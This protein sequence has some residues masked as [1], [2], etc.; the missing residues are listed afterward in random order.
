MYLLVPLGIV[1]G[2]IAL[3]TNTGTFIVLFYQY[4]EILFFLNV[5]E[6][7]VT[8]STFLLNLVSRIITFHLYLLN[9]RYHIFTYAL[10]SQP[11]PSVSLC[12]LCLASP[13]PF[14]VICTF[15]HVNS[16]FILQVI[17][18]CIYFNCL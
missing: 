12:P 18:L 5:S 10:S 3:K 8:D 17:A 11:V 9:Y 2:I 16:C 4:P 1:Q 7:M 6:H 14:Y 15:H 13:P